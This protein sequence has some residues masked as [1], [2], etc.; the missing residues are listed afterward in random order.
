[1]LDALLIKK[2]VRKM[3]KKSKLW[4]YY[5]I[6][7]VI[8]QAVFSTADSN[9]LFQ[10]MTSSG[11]KVLYSVAYVCINTLLWLAMYTGRKLVDAAAHK[12][13]YLCLTAGIV[14]GPPSVIYSL[15]RIILA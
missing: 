10:A 4:L 14:L 15:I 2:K 12:W 13:L 8:I 9:G 11:H 6:L 5:L 1:L 7:A 3:E